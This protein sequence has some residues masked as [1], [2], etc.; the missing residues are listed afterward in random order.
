MKATIKK[1]YPEYSQEE[2]DMTIQD[3]KAC[4][5]TVCSSCGENLEEDDLQY[6]RTTGDGINDPLEHIYT[7]PCCG[8]DEPELIKLSLDKFLENEKSS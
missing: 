2:V 1:Y 7:C 3:Y 6:S 5:D 8:I 4:T